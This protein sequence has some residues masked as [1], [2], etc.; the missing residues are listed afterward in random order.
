MLILIH[1]QR[2]HSSSLRHSESCCSKNRSAIGLAALQSRRSRSRRNH[3]IDQMKTQLSMPSEG[4]MRKAVS[5]RDQHYDGSFVYGVIT[6]GVYCH[7]SCKSRRAKA[8]NI[9][10]FAGPEA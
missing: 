4:V 2:I 8:A 6:T 10:F 3:M 1:H 9:L 7:P 5:E